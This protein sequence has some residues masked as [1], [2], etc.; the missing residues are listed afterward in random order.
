MKVVAEGTE[1]VDKT[2]KQIQAA[3]GLADKG[4]AGYYN[5]TGFIRF[6]Q[7]VGLAKEVGT[8]PVEAAPEPKE[9]EKKKKSGG[10]G[11]KLWRIPKKIVITAD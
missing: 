5:T 9:G 6:L 2:A 1:T 11:A 10:K 8:A 4:E 7:E 3:C